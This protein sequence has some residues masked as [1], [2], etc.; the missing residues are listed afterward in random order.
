MPEAGTPE[1]TPKQTGENLRQKTR[2]IMGKFGVGKKDIVVSSTGANRTGADEAP[3][4]MPNS[5]DKNPRQKMIEVMNELASKRNEL[6]VLGV[7]SDPNDPDKR[8]EIFIEPVNAIKD[9]SPEDGGD[10]DIV[11]ATT[12][13][14]FAIR[15]T[16]SPEGQSAAANLGRDLSWMWTG[17]VGGIGKDKITITD[18]FSLERAGKYNELV[19][20]FNLFAPNHEYAERGRFAPS[21]D[22]S[23]KSVLVSKIVPVGKDTVDRAFDASREKARESKMPDAK[24]ALRSMDTNA[25]ADSILDKLENS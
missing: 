6:G 4:Q 13:G 24:S 19:L 12:Q 14:F 1:Q 9:K 20:K 15:F 5:E 25:A 16:G 23:N 22:N 10:S 21:F 2:R 18:T 11:I 7:G 3:N 8:V 17:A